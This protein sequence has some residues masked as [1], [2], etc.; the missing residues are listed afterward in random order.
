MPGACNKCT[1]QA[2][3]P[4]RSD[5]WCACRCLSY[6][7]SCRCLPCGIRADV[8]VTRDKSVGFAVQHMRA[9]WHSRDPQVAV[10]GSHCLC[11]ATVRYALR[12]ST[13]D[14][15]SHSAKSGELTWHVCD[16]LPALLVLL[17]TL[18]RVPMSIVMWHCPRAK[19]YARISQSDLT[20]SSVGE[21]MYSFCTGS[22]GHTRGAVGAHVHCC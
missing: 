18:K 22:H 5:H 6:R 8:L 3:W 20:V 10:Q 19:G 17:H 13:K 12:V 15:G 14:V 1:A 7:T 4:G 2:R 11:R 16:V 21:F 9:A